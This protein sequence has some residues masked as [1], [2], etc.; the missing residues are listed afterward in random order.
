MNTAY[1]LGAGASHSYVD[2]HSGTRPPLA[3]DFFSTYIQLPISEDFEV[4]V[5]DVVNYVRDFYNTSPA[6]FSTFSMNVETFMTELDGKIR[7]LA[8]KIRLRKLDRKELSNFFTWVKAYDQMI[9]LF[10]HVIN[11]TQRGP[12]SKQYAKLASMCD[13]SDVL[14]TFNWDT[15]L[16]RALYESGTW[17]PDTG[18]GVNFRNILDADWRP[19]SLQASSILLLKLHGSVNWLVNYVTRHMTTGERVMVT[20]QPTPGKIIISLD[21]GFSIENGI[22]QV[23]PELNVRQWGSQPIPGPEEPS[24]TPCCFLRGPKPFRAYRNRYRFGYQDFGYFFPPNDPTGDIPM[25][26]L[27]VPPTNFKLYDEFKHVLDPLWEEAK[28]RITDSHRI[29]IIGYS[30]PPTDHRVTGLLQPLVSLSSSALTIQVV[31][32]SPET[33]CQRIINEIGIKSECLRVVA[34]SFDDYL[35]L[36]H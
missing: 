28:R 13:K 3:N 15:L 25:M 4:R 17:I 31:N 6:R 19:P 2:S 26:P 11:E 36:E 24:A 30:F 27:I 8:D 32:P 35:Q 18:Y 16:D 5:G 14:I 10:A 29:V 22:L 1:V 21:P 12:V 20:G 23:H 33:V 9:F 34:R 7:F